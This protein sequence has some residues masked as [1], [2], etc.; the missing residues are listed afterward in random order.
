MIPLKKI[1]TGFE[2]RLYVVLCSMGM[3]GFIYKLLQTGG[4]FNKT[5]S[6]ALQ[7]QSFE[8]RA[9]TTAD[10]PSRNATFRGAG[11]KF[12]SKKVSSPQACNKS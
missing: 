2:T 10:Q 1:T 7:M 12:P 11:T 6:Q 5:E 9:N 4:W 3:F 8:F